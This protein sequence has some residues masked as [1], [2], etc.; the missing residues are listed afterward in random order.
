MENAS[1]RTRYSGEIK[2]LGVLDLPEDLRTILLMQVLG[3]MSSFQ[4]GEVLGKPA[5]TIRYQIS[6]ARKRLAEEI[7]LIGENSP[8]KDDSL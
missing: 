4:I 3:E 6:L 2:N 5:G 7:R 8:Q 1:E